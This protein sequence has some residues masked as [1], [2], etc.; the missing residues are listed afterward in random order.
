LLSVLKHQGGPVLDVVVEHAGSG[1]VARLAGA[2]DC[3]VHP[4]APHLR[5]LMPYFDTHWADTA[6]YRDVLMRELTSFPPN[7]PLT[8]R[9][10]WGVAGESGATLETLQAQILDRWKLRAAILNPMFAGSMMHDPHLGQ[11]LC[12]AH[13]D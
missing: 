6:R 11:A 7:A 13:N 4:R 12:R 9:P 10:D 5:E 3:D 8:R 1:E 2:I